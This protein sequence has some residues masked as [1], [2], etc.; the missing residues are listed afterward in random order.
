MEHY[1][2][3]ITKKVPSGGGIVSLYIATSRI[4]SPASLAM[5]APSYSGGINGT[6]MNHSAMFS[7]NY[8]LC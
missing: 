2:T 3:L 6:T 5:A 8:L 7:P 1:Q 4:Y